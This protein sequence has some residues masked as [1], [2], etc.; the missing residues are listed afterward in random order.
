M[1]FFALWEAGGN[2]GPYAEQRDET[3][4]PKG[5]ARSYIGSSIWASRAFVSVESRLPLLS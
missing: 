4:A 1:I 5:A 3:G 2:A